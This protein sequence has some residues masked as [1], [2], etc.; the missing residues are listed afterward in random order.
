MRCLSGIIAIALVSISGTHA[1]LEAPSFDV[2]NIQQLT[3]AACAAMENL[4]SYF[5]PNSR[6]TFNETV[7]PWHE[8]GMIWGLNFDYARWTGDTKYLDIV[9]QALV[10]Q[11]NGDVHDFLA[12]GAKE[13]WND[14]ILWPS[15][16]GE[17]SNLQA[18]H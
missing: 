1:S 17:T 8:S 7:T 12:P 4:M 18:L 10:N 14:D 2:H 3:E 13:Q 16:A 6:G 11:S 9:T 15:Q 5:T